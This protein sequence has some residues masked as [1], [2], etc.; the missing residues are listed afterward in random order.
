VSSSG[1]ASAPFGGISFGGSTLDKQCDMRE[2]A[3][4]FALLG[5]RYAAAK[6]LCNTD[7]AK[8]AHLS[9]EE[10]LTSVPDGEQQHIYANEQIGVNNS[11]NNGNMIVPATIPVN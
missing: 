7:A 10:C 9:I 3:R 4:A 11:I 5:S 2:T 6:I 8:K 1:G